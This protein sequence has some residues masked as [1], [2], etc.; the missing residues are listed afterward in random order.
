MNVNAPLLV[1]ALLGSL[2]AL[3]LAGCSGESEP[4]T[5]ERVATPASDAVAKR[6]W[7]DPV[8]KIEPAVWLASREAGHDVAPGAPSVVAWQARL[9]AADA[10]FGE[11]DRMIA[12]RAAQL[13]TM[14]G[15]IGVRE[16]ASQIV[17]AFMPFAE[18][19]SRRGFSDL[20]QHYYNLR[21]QGLSQPEALAAL[22]AEPVRAEP[23][24]PADPPS[25]ASSSPTLPS[26]ASE[27]RP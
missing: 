15:E 26:P 11:T 13:E 1:R 4:E 18:K 12:N 16:S 21:K 22:K 23:V 3:P 24:A 8:D 2:L 19:G 20:C 27:V 17:D 14:L 9:D 6:A 5:R 25:P 7:L 10:R